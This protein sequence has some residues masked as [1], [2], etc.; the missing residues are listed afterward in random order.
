MFVHVVRV[1]QYRY[2]QVVHSVWRQGKRTPGRKHLWSIGRYDE[3]VLAD[4]RRL[5][6]ELVEMGQAQT[7]LCP[8][9][10]VA[11]SV[12]AAIDR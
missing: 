2:R 10:A 1:G 4:A 12:M 6:R 9:N 3:R 7:A 5:L 8:G 11:N